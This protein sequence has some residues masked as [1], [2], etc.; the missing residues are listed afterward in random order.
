MSAQ[1]LAA[2]ATG[3]EKLQ[4]VV[5]LGASNVSI[6]FPLIVNLLREG[7]DG[8][9]HVCAA[10]GHGRSYGIW[11]SIGPRGLPSIR[12]SGLWNHLSDKR[13]QDMRPKA[14]ITDIGND[15]MYQLTPRTIVHW[16]RECIER[17]LESNSEILLTMLPM[18]SVEKLSRSKFYVF[19]SV[20]FP[21]NRISF[22]DLSQLVHELDERI[23]ELVAAYPV[24]SLEPPGEWYGL[25][26]I[27]IRRG[28]RLSA[29]S[30]YFSHWSDWRADTSRPAQILSS[31]RSGR[32][33]PLKRRWFGREQFFSQPTWQHQTT[34]V[35]LF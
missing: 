32:L 21:A 19:R 20:F 10:E 23:R 24:T 3:S 1:A 2:D 12:D 25:D 33:K 11:S 26:P 5:L 30:H 16:V 22:D 34:E 31:L 27:H 8:P 15:L 18:G 13:Q 28:S 4:N 17:L 7:F 6:G 29:W 35:S 14:L 9:L